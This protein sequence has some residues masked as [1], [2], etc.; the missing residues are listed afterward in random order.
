MLAAEN[1]SQCGNANCHGPGGNAPD[2]REAHVTF[3]NNDG[4]GVFDISILEVKVEN[5]DA[6]PA[7]RVKALRGTRATGTSFTGSS[8]TGA[9]YWSASQ[10]TLGLVSAITR[11]N[12]AM[13]EPAPIMN[14][15]NIAPLK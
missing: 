7:V 9:P 10:G 4:A 15:K 13:N 3:L 2:A 1:P 5:A 11:R 14:A 8:T 6:A 12:V